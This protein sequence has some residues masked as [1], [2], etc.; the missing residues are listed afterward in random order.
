MTPPA[1]T[2]ALEPGPAARAP[3]AGATTHA[4]DSSTAPAQASEPEVNE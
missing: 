4:P 2:A 1:G 3:S